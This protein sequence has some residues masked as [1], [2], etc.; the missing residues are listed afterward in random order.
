MYRSILERERENGKSFASKL[1]DTK[2]KDLFNQMLKSVNKYSGAIKAKGELYATQ[3]LLMSLMLEQHK[4]I[5][6]K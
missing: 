3:S 4:K 5:G 6:M 1:S 2:D